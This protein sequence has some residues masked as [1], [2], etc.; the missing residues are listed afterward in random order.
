MQPKYSEGDYLVFSSYKEV[1]PLVLV[2]VVEVWPQTTGQVMY[3][4]KTVWGEPINAYE[5]Q[6]SVAPHWDIAGA[7]A[8][9]ST[10]AK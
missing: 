6:L 10:P 3:W 2:Q 1:M 4:C 5:H 7:F 8:K 9:A